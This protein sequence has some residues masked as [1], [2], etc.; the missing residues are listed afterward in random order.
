MSSSTVIPTLRPSELTQIDKDIG[1]SI[2]TINDVIGA[3]DPKKSSEHTIKGLVIAFAEIYT[4]IT[5]KAEVMGDHSDEAISDWLTHVLERIDINDA[6]MPLLANLQDLV[7]NSNK[8]VIEFRNKEIG[9]VQA[10]LEDLQISATVSN[11][12]IG[13]ITAAIDKIHTTALQGCKLFLSKIAN[14]PDPRLN[15]PWMK[16]NESNPVHHLLNDNLDIKDLLKN[17][18]FKAYCKEHAQEIES[19]VTTLNHQLST[20]D[21]TQSSAIDTIISLKTELESNIVGHLLKVVP[22]S[23]N[24]DNPNL[25]INNIKSLNPLMLTSEA[26]NQLAYIIMAAH[27]I[28]TQSEKHGG[29]NDINKKILSNAGQSPDLLKGDNRHII[30]V[31]RKTLGDLSKQYQSIINLLPPEQVESVQKLINRLKG[32]DPGLDANQL[33]SYEKAKQLTFELLKKDTDFN[34]NLKNAIKDVKDLQVSVDTPHRPT[35]Y[36]TLLDAVNAH[37]TP[38]KKRDIVQKASFRHKVAEIKYTLSPTELTLLSKVTDLDLTSA[39]FKKKDGNL[40][41]TD[42]VAQINAEILRRNLEN[43]KWWRNLPFCSLEVDQLKTAMHYIQYHNQ[44]LTLAKSPELRLAPD[45]EQGYHRQVN[46]GKKSRKAFLKVIRE[47]TSFFGPKDLYLLGQELQKKTKDARIMKKLAKLDNHATMAEKLNPTPNNDT[48]GNRTHVQAGGFFK[49][50]GIIGFRD[51]LKSKLNGYLKEKS[52]T[53]IPTDYKFFE[54][55]KVGDLKNILIMN[56]IMELN[57]IETNCQTPVGFNH[58]NEM[59][60]NVIGIQLEAV[61]TAKKDLRALADKMVQTNNIFKEAKLQVI[62]TLGTLRG[63]DPNEAI[64]MLNVVISASDRVVRSRGFSDQIAHNITDVKTWDEAGVLQLC[65]HRE[66]VKDLT[67]V[68]D[69][70]SANSQQVNVSEVVS[71]SVATLTAEVDTM[72]SEVNSVQVGA[73]VECAKQTAEALTYLSDH[74]TASLTGKNP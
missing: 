30:L 35:T 20:L 13:Q 27:H 61:K 1:L 18:H 46:S 69:L 3:H 55:L 49:P 57:T 17:A 41:Y 54:E 2:E 56:M 74:R 36:K 47:Q 5:K 52:W 37:P 51:T 9:P 21:V 39:Q 24:L 70:L 58:T 50:S 14:L 40:S 44:K 34:L 12:V 66:M 59:A 68:K 16:K 38:L 72:R 53:T 23:S 43:K 15:E 10:K 65:K 45:G 6:L 33:A 29:N 64:Q 62:E 48:Q 42:A 71:S 60:L 26:L 8:V 28:S 63:L 7:K 73:L 25:L 32:P 11:Q 22:N 4:Q 67:A 19:L 31:V